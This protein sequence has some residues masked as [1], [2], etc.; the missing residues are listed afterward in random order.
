MLYEVITRL[1]NGERFCALIRG[2][3]QVR[4]VICGHLHQF[5]ITSYNVC[6]TKLLRIPLVLETIDDTIWAEEIAQLRRFQAAA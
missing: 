5:R 2:Y 1:A 3:P 4:A 6:Y